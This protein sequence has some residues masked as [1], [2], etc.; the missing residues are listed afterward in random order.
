M[1]SIIVENKFESIRTLLDR[2][3]LSFRIQA[4]AELR[5]DFIR[6]HRYFRRR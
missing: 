2:L 4:V 3:S 5:L 6:K 1:H